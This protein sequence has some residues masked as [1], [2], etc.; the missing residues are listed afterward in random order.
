LTQKKKQ[1]QKTSLKLKDDGWKK[2]NPNFEEN[3]KSNCSKCG[4]QA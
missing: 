1:L 2:G 3:K 4:M